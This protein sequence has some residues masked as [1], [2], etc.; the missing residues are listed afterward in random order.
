MIEDPESEPV[1][2][3][4]AESS[5]DGTPKLRRFSMKAYN[6]GR[7]NVGFGY[8]VVVDLSGLRVTAKARPILRQHDP[9]RIVGHTDS[10]KINDG[11]I[12]VSGT[13]SGANDHSREVVDAADAGFPW[14]AS[15]GASVKRMVFVDKGE[16]A[17]ANGRT[18]TGPLYVARQSVLGEV[19]FVP[20]GADDTT[21]ARMVAGATESFLEASSMKFE[22]WLA[23][24]GLVQASL[25]ED[26]LTALRAMFDAETAEDTVAAAA[27]DDTVQAAA[28]DGATLPSASADDAITAIRAESARINQINAACANHPE[29]AATAIDKGWD[30]ARAQTQVELVELRASRPTA[31][32]L[33][34]G[35]GGPDR[36]SVISAAVHSAA[37]LDD[38][39]VIAETDEASLEAAQREFRAGIGL[40][41]LLLEAA[42]A[43]GY[44]QR[45]IRSVVN[46]LG[47]V[48]RAAFSTT[49][50]SGILGNVANKGVAAAFDAVESG[51]RDITAIRPV[52]D[53]K[54]HT[55]YSLTGD[56][57]YEE[58]AGDGE[59]KHGTV[60]EESYTNQAKTYGKLFAITRKDII[61]DDLGM[62]ASV[63]R[64]I[65]RGAALK[66]NTV[67]WTE[68]MDNASFF[69][70]GRNNRETG[71]GSALDIDALTAAELAF[72]DQTD[73]DGQ[74]LGVMP[75]IL[76]V[77]NALNVLATRLMSASGVNNGG[78]ST[79]TPDD[80]PHA[81]KFNVVRSS[82][83]SNSTI[84]GNST[85]AWYLL[86]DPMDLPVIEV[87]FLNGVETPTVESADADFDTLGI[88]VRGYHDFGV[89]KQEYRGGV[90]NDGV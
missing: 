68:F 90:A 76:L 34:L 58:V 33:N 79:D 48:L 66:L 72:L 55:S 32:N 37:N 38:Q 45:S 65:G 44:Q 61:N 53:F 83:L 82:Y 12:D 4:A 22:Q 63:P 35:N 81:G 43:N 67:F 87:A 89:T 11:S 7:L 77:P 17:Q 8:P 16:T 50:L 42:I 62:F 26:T 74:P 84:T 19:S 21:S 41:E 40:Q 71:A 10:V 78:G 56:L 57:E 52:N 69:T 46:D 70:A 6:G 51:W 60:G 23:S 13:V 5:E 49:S 47:G 20:L 54:T 14:Q 64:K 59:L 36:M 3:Q 85:T 24:K 80:N 75:A 88:Q 1:A 73:P 39:I 30:V 27:G 15:I 2:L 31:P 29:I 9:D 28:G 25:D 18:F 86:A